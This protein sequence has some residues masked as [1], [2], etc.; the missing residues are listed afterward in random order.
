MSS[1]VIRAI[2]PSD[3]D[4]VHKL[5]WQ[6]GYQP[7]LDLV[8]GN[9]DRML[10][11]SDYELVGAA[12]ENDTVIA[13]MSLEVRL[14]IEDISF[15]QIGAL[16]TSEPCRGK[17]VGRQLTEYAEKAALKHGLSFVGLYSSKPRSS[18]HR[19]YEKLG[20]ERFKES[21]FFKKVV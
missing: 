19:F 1:I 5:A 15:L 11:H 13:W 3:A 21:F 20:Y 8:K 4:V 14:R 16:V 9:I 2:R 18:A 7:T 6:L 10:F 12:D 17:G